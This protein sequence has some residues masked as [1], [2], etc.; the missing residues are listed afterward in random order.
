MLQWMGIAISID[1]KACDFSRGLFTLE[2]A[3]VRLIQAPCQGHEL[4][5]TTSAS[6]RHPATA[7]NGLPNEAHILPFS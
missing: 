5:A 7:D 6:G 1:N 2:T 4:Q 3:G